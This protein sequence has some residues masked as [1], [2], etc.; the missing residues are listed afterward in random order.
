MKIQSDPPI[1]L[2]YCLNIH[3]CETWEENFAAI[4]EHAL[5][6]R[7]S[8]APDKAFG[9]GLRLSNKAAK[10]LSVVGKLQEFKNFLAENNLY[11]FTING[12]PYGRFHGTKVK[13][14][15]YKPDWRTSE[16]RDYT[17]A[18]A[19]ILSALLPENVEGSIS[20]VPCT[21]KS[22]ISTEDGD[23]G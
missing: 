7:D 22:W 18:L 6:V 2:T 21:Y 5:A 4:K 8:V 11:V 17:I 3:P 14:N 1:H 9:L 10:A 12:F 20:T 13:E 16:R 15:V 23:H 19:D